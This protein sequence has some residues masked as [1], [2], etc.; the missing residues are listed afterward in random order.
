MNF[1]KKIIHVDMDC[2][3]AAVEMRDN[4]RYRNLPIAV[5]GDPKKRG[6]VATANYSAR[7]YGIHSAMPMAQAIKLCPHLTVVAGRHVVYKEVSNQ[8][9]HIF[10]QYTPF[11]EALSLDEAYLDVTHCPLF[12]GSA[13]LIAQ[14]IRHKIAQE[15]NLTASAGVAP[16]KFLAKI[17][18]DINKPNGQYVIPPEQVSDFIA[19]LPLKKIPGVGRVTEKKLAELG[20]VYCRD[21]LNF[22]LS[23]LLNQFGK[24]GRILY[25]RCQGIDEREVNNDRQR[26]SV[27]VERTLATD[28]HTWQEC[29]PFFDSLYDELE[30][31]LKKVRADCTIARQGVKFKFQDFQLTTQ[32]HIYTKLDKHDLIDLAYQIW[33]ERR[34]DRGVRLIG[35]HVTLIDPQLDKQL[36]LTL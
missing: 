24:F 7:Q 25:E 35:F 12:Q 17:A 16:L 33:Q 20:L 19:N 9:H 13:T 2:F 30:L 3:Y 31:R 10:K 8:I 11:I 4:P 27:G 1:V 18:S 32:E 5:G 29:L 6:V 28:I 21:V 36:L 15:L 23:R 22:D 26:K 34:Q 14:D